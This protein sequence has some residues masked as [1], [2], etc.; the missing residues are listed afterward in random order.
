[1]TRTPDLAA[2][3]ATLELVHGWPGLDADDRATSPWGSPTT[4]E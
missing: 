4:P 3:L 1:M 2:M